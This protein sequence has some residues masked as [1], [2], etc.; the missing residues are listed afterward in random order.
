MTDFSIKKFLAALPAAL[1][2]VTLLIFP[3]PLL[4]AARG[5][6]LLWAK[7]VVPSLFP[8]MVC[9][10]ILV[11]L[12]AAQ[13]LG[14]LLSPVMKPLFG[15]SGAGAL[16]LF[17]G[18]LCGYPMGAKLIGTLLEEREITP[19]EADRLMTF[20]NHPGPL[21]VLGTVGSGLLG[22]PAAGYFLLA[23]IPLAGLITGLIFR[24]FG[25]RN[26]A[27]SKNKPVHRRAVKPFSQVLTE[28]VTGSAATLITVGGFI[29]LFGV[30]AEA[31]RLWGV[32]S[33]LPTGMQALVIGLLEMTTGANLAVKA[34]LPL[35]P[36]LALLAGMLAWG[37]CSIH[38]QIA[39]VLQG[40]GV[41]ISHYIRAKALHGLLAGVGA[42]LAYPLI[43]G[44][45]KTV[46]V[47]QLTG[48]TDSLLFGYFVV[49]LLLLAALFRL[50]P[51]RRF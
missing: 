14:P 6:L 11:G 19:E 8:F 3:Q 34:A 36:T 42:Y 43:F 2:L 48:G 31:L 30:L 49:G 44:Q 41:S 5:S 32:L 15:V 26:A 16:P 35:R 46:P 20:C 1:L 24:I 21:F 38:A 23:V 17:L 12:G 4:D 50:V 33:W 13:T 28:A 51:K 27:A 7:I 39:G 22:S 10:S 9:T 45:N 29:L 47:L 25:R 18:L 40:S 37:G